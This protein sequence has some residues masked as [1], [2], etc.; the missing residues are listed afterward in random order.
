MLVPQDKKGARFVF[1]V[2]SLQKPP[3]P[4]LIPSGWELRGFNSYW[5]WQGY[6]PSAPN[7]PAG[8]PP[9]DAP[10]SDTRPT[11]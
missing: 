7:D 4:F 11:E 5:I 3:R 1:R 8:C 6:N 2:E 10:E 9:V